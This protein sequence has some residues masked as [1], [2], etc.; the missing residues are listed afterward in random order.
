MIHSTMSL[1]LSWKMILLFLFIRSNVRNRNLA[2]ASTNPTLECPSSGF[3]VI[4][5]GNAV[6]LAIASKGKLCTLTQSNVDGT[7]ILPVGRSY[8]GFEWESVAGPYPTL[9]Y[10]CDNASCEVTLP[11]L[12][13]PNQR[14]QLT[15]FGRNISRKDTLARFFEQATFGTTEEDLKKLADEDQDVM[16]LNSYFANWTH[17]Q[18]YQEKLTSHRNFWRERTLSHSQQS[19]WREGK[20]PRPCEKG[21]HWR[22]YAFTKHDVNENV[23]I[24]LKEGVFSFSI[25]GE[26]RTTVSSFQLEET[27]FENFSFPLIVRVCWVQTH[28]S[29]H[30]TLAYDGKCRTLIG[31]N[32]HVSIH[33]STDYVALIDS[34]DMSE[35]VLDEAHIHRMILG[36]N[37]QS[38]QCALD[39]KSIFIK[40]NHANSV[41]HLLY[42]PRLMLKENLMV[43][44]L[45]DGGGGVLDEA[46]GDKVQCSNVVR[47]FLNENS[48]RLATDQQTCS[49][50]KYIAGSVKLNIINM[51]KLFEGAWRYVY[52]VTNLRLEDD[53]EVES[54]CEDGVRSRW[55]QYD[56]LTI[57]D[58]NVHSETASIFRKLIEDGNDPNPHVKDLFLP[59]GKTCH[60]DDQ[61]T[62]QMTIEVGTVCWRTVHPDHLDVYDFSGWSQ[63][64]P[65]N[66]S[67][68]KSIKQFALDGSYTLKYPSFHSMDR[69]KDQKKNLSYLGRL[70]DEVEFKNFPDSLRTV[71]IADLF[72]LVTPTT[73]DGTKAIIC[74]SPFEGKSKLFHNSFSITRRP[75]L[76]FL[77]PHQFAQQKRTV[78]IMIA[79]TAADQLRQRVAW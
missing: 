35:F 72:G 55:K 57:C 44:P 16:D 77:K 73:E 33:E 30:V 39:N 17:H 27:L 34:A 69:W 42:D 76:D 46:G 10:Q 65:G 79:T 59:S 3:E 38:D 64:H 78:W 74:G 28:I 14:F 7:T 25:G 31:G 71:L 50:K 67:N 18:I 19:Y 63:N 62:V 75:G 22:G 13:D 43:N 12:N 60:W 40:V 47:N 9:S 32:P 58:E 26:L 11:Q 45:S 23:Q 70:G 68:K 37:I 54:P 1:S 6:R 66:D 8:D 5:S 36:S 4:P 15:S 21:S 51:K 24:E 29:G 48:C 52:G 20:T 2:F 56:D 49:P 61:A 41:Q 53:Y